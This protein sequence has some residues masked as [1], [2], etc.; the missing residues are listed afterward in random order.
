M[1]S[2]ETLQPTSFLDQQSELSDHDHFVRPSY[3]QNAGKD[4]MI[5]SQEVVKQIRV[6]L[7]HLDDEIRD[8]RY[9]HLLRKSKVDF[10]SLRA[11]PAHQYH[12]ISSDLRSVAMMIHRFNEP[13]VHSYFMKVFQ[14]EAEALTN[15]LPLAQK[16]GMSGE[17]LKHYP[18]TPEGF[19]YATYM[20]W[21][22]MYGSAA[23]IVA[24]F[25]AN[26]PTWGYNCGQMSQSLRKHYGFA[27]EETIFLEAFA[28]LPSFESVALPIIQKGLDE[29]VEPWQIQRAAYLFQGYEKMFWDSMAKLGSM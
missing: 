20:G 24:G 26:F 23:E 14:G 2:L 12:I 6:E 25:L 4:D 1:I 15:L 29:G 21:L 16:L 11:F 27:P 22:S 18:I 8:H 7:R 3:F 28:N 9:L 19:A 5:S 10:P 17:E 13:T